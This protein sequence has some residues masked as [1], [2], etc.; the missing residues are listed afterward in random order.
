MKLYSFFTGVVAAGL[1]GAFAQP[2]PETIPTSVGIVF[3][4]S[5]SMGFRLGQARQIV[6]AVTNSATA[7]DEFAVIQT[8]NRPIALSGFIGASG[9]LPTLQ[10]TQAKGKSALLDGIYLGS[11]LMKMAHHERKVLLVISDGVDNAS[12]FT[13]TE[14]AS[15]LR[16]AGIRVYLVG[17]G[18][19]GDVPA[20][21]PRI[22]EEAHGRSFDVD[23]VAR[24]PEI[25]AELRAAMR[26]GQAATN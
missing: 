16:E 23:D 7:E 17:L 10:Y 5:G 15:A 1:C 22:A 9:V 8:A 4:T 19:P 18:K 25:A 26:G 12:R 3:D 13:E 24:L 14:I 11:Q 21:L 6:A 2:S 20:L